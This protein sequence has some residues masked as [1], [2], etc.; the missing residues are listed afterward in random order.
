MDE[1][2]EENMKKIAADF[3]GIYLSLDIRHIY[4]GKVEDKYDVMA[5]YNVLDLLSDFPDFVEYVNADGEKRNRMINWVLR[6]FEKIEAFRRGCICYR[7]EWYESLLKSK[8]LKKRRKLIDREIASRVLKILSE[9]RTG[10]HI[11]GILEKEGF[12]TKYE[13]Y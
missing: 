6:Y 5:L 11:L 8:K 12:V 10:K 3:G 9:R 13:M 1:K 4:R 7:H 2:Y